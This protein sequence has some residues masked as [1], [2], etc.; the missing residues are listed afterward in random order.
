V[1]DARVATGA[2][3]ERV[4]ELAHDFRAE[5]RDQRGGPLWATREAR[6]EPFTDALATLLAYDD[7]T[8]IV[9]T[10]DDSIV[11]YGI[12]E[13]EELRDGSR[14]GVVSEIFVET[15]AR[16]VGVGELL[17]NALVAFCVRAGCVGVDAAALPGDRQAKN[18][19]E[20]AGFTARLLVMHHNTAPSSGVPSRAQRE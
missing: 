12:A 9:G 1:E 7:S 10:L 20:R 14:L 4:A 19:F 15:E 11:G 3:L 5:L 16:A 6:P 8:V 13:I 17:V 2:A 18:F